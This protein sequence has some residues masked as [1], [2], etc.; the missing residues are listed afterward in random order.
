MPPYDCKD[1]GE[2]DCE[3]CVYCGYRR[4]DNRNNVEPLALDSYFQK[5]RKTF[6]EELNVHEIFANRN[7]MGKNV[8]YVQKGL[9]ALLN[10]CI[11]NTESQTHVS[12]QSIYQIC[13]VFV[14]GERIVLVCED[15]CIHFIYR[16]QQHALVTGLRNIANA[17]A[18]DF[19][20]ILVS[21]HSIDCVCVRDGKIKW[22]QI[23]VLDLHIFE[24]GDGR[25]TKIVGLVTLG[26]NKCAL[27]FCSIKSP[28]CTYEEHYLSV[29]DLRNGQ[30]ISTTCIGERK[31][32][33]MLQPIKILPDCKLT[34][35]NHNDVTIPHE[36]GKVVVHVEG[37]KDGS[38]G[39]HV[40]YDKPEDW[41]YC[42]LDQYV[43]LGLDVPGNAIIRFQNGNALRTYAFAQDTLGNF[44]IL[45]FLCGDDVFVIL[46]P[47]IVM[48]C[49]YR[50]QSKNTVK[51]ALD[52][53][54]AKAKLLNDHASAD[55]ILFLF[56]EENLSWYRMSLKR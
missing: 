44:K 26:I 14:C 6:L 4:H 22:T 33:H 36:S 56:Q 42:R 17:I 32:A 27:V 10:V 52:F 3:R 19:C 47:N 23:C 12:I 37:R 5:S 13:F 2:L 46:T 53:V 38:V 28:E 29:L 41:L 20:I 49:Y 45:D 9:D 21:K 30:Y 51:I 39:I 11:L 18:T 24:G 35:T 31:A 34:Q 16:S 15:G 40:T 55:A 48:Y 43:L 54:P 50:M 1:C 8:A 7:R 25:E